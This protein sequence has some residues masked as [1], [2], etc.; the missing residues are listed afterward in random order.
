[1]VGDRVLGEG[2]AIAF[3][4]GWLGDRVLGNRVILFS[5]KSAI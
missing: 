2:W 1:V 4:G 3:F 5:R